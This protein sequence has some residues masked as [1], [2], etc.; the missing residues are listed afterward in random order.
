MGPGLLELKIHATFP[1]SQHALH[2]S[3]FLFKHCFKC[4]EATNKERRYSVS[5]IGWKW[6]ELPEP[7]TYYGNHVWDHRHQMA[8]HL[9]KEGL[10]AK[11]SFTPGRNGEVPII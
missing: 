4:P 7:L 9:W 8:T 6:T 3:N 11:H 1:D 10:A 2:V 5:E